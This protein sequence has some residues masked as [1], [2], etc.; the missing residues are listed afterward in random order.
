M[1][2]VN[3]QLQR[4]KTGLL[5]IADQPL[6]R[7]RRHPATSALPSSRKFLSAVSPVFDK[8]FK[9]LLDILDAFNSTPFLVQA[10]AAARRQHQRQARMRLFTPFEAGDPIGQGLK[11]AGHLEHLRPDIRGLRIVD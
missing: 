9:D 4:F 10:S 11:L 2:A 1:P 3:C 8:S 6:E 7:F 5:C